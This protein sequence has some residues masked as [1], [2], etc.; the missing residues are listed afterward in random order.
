MEEAVKLV[1]ARQ[2]GGKAMIDLHLHTYYSDGNLSPDDVIKRAAA[3]GATVVAITDHDAIDGIPEALKAGKKY[4]VRVIPGLEFSAGLEEEEPSFGLPDYPGQEVFMHILGYNIDLNN[5]A[6]KKIMEFLRKERHQRNEKLLAE[7]Q[8]LGFHLSPEDLR[9]RPDQDYVGKP[10]FAVALAQK[11]YIEK[12][13]DAFAS[14]ENLRHPDVLAIKRDKILAKNCVRL[15]REAGGMAVLAH[16]MKIPFLGRKKPGY[17]DRL[18]VLLDQ[19]L[20]WGLHG[21]ECCYNQHSP[22]ETETL[23]Q[24]ARVRG[25]LITGGSDYHGPG[26]NRVKDI[27]DFYIPEDLILDIPC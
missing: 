15:I 14:K 6:L 1:G 10:N 22:E 24:M 18:S 21:L 8:K 12:P 23:I 16:P 26:I 20:G 11:G 13:S 17:F 3:R 19:L 27:G 2:H 7:L 25:L 5:E 4:G 9:Q